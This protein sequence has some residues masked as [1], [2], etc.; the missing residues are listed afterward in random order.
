MLAIFITTVAYI[1]VAIC[2]GERNIS[3]VRTARSQWFF[4]S[5][6]FQRNLSKEKVC[7]LKAPA[8][9]LFLVLKGLYLGEGEMQL[10]CS[11]VTLDDSTEKAITPNA[12]FSCLVK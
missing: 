2:V 10:E 9:L 4:V 7:F 6:G 5:D 1:G 12:Q 11:L 3:A 8:L